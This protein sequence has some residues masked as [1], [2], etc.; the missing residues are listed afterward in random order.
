MI[1]KKFLSWFRKKIDIKK[2]NYYCDPFT[3]DLNGESLGEIIRDL[4]MDG[5]LGHFTSSSLF[6]KGD[7]DGNMYFATRS[8]W[9]EAGVNPTSTFTRF[10]D[11]EQTI[12]S[13]PDS[14]N[15]VKPALVKLATELIDQIRI[16]NTDVMLRKLL[17][18]FENTYEFY[19]QDRKTREKVAKLYSD[20]S[21]DTL[22]NN[23]SI[24]MTLL[25][26]LSIL[27]EN[28]LVFQNETKTENFEDIDLDSPD[29]MFDGDLL[30]KTYL[31]ALLSQFYTLLNLSKD[32]KKNY[33]YCSGISINPNDQ[34]PIDGIIHHPLLYTSVLITGNQ[35]ALSSEYEADFLKN[36]NTTPIGQGFQSTYGISFIN[37]IRVLDELEKDF[38]GKITLMPVDELKIYIK[39]RC[40][41]D[42]NPDKL[43][44]HF[45]INKSNLMQYITK[46]EPYIFRVGCNQ[47]RL[48]IRPIVLLDNGTAYISPSAINKAINCWTSYAKN[49][50]K[51]YTGIDVGQGD[52]IIDGFAKREEELSNRLVDILC[53][54]LEQHYPKAVFKDKNV[55]YHR[56]FGKRRDRF[57]D[58]ED[59]DIIY[60]TG[61]E[62]FLIEAK[63]FSDSLTINLVI[64]DYNKIFKDGRY[65]KH[66]RARYDLVEEESEMIKAFVKAV[67]NVQVHYLFISSKPL[68][69]EFQD[70]DKL[71]TFLSVA[72]FDNYLDG[73]LEYDNGT[74]LRPTHT[75]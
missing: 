30:Q 9:I 16:T 53:R 8:F 39:T 31:Y 42:I 38:R 4:E 1:F 25:N 75:I 17:I 21:D 2:N 26:G 27:I 41:F 28:C 70:E 3:M 68:E 71:V 37:M 12:N 59:Y 61:D 57:Q 36:I 43:L 62:L 6:H 33:V 63:Y 15:F 66:C 55:K 40:K 18:L 52:T 19:C 23:R 34:V 56:I 67:G 72:N 45:S 74:T 24:T 47:F 49:G 44:E 54:K 64:S 14:I 48:D 13:I 32:S 11:K 22:E 10:L 5:K 7:S 58:N 65:Y 50:G 46:N 69:I 60:F 51:P 73:K 35:K 29:D 20:F